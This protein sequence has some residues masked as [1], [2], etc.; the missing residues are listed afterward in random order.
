MFNCRSYDLNLFMILW[1]LRDSELERLSVIEY[2]HRTHG[3]VSI[4]FKLQ[5]QYIFNSFQDPI[6]T[7]VFVFC[8][9]RK[10]CYFPPLPFCPSG[11]V[12]D[13]DQCIL[14]RTPGS[15]SF[16]FLIVSFQNSTAK[17]GANASVRRFVFFNLAEL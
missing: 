15:A 1:P 13:F 14:W 11:S 9:W 8:T 4:L 16:S 10:S 7:R 3:K 6:Q 2:C 12:M 17:F 5:C